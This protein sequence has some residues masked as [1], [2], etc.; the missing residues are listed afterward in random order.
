[1]YETMFN[2]KPIPWVDFQSNFNVRKK[3]IKKYNKNSLH[4]SISK[5]PS[6]RKQRIVSKNQIITT[7]LDELIE[8]S[9]NITS[10]IKKDISTSKDSSTELGDEIDSKNDSY[11][12]SNTDIDLNK[13]KLKE[14]EDL[15]NLI[16]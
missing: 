15:Q 11:S 8:V 10:T 9:L 3:N 14:K 5:L 16:N 2:K 1:M 4:N 7:G 12:S 6:R 13:Q